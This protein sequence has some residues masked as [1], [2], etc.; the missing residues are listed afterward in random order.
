MN[1]AKE[2]MLRVYWD[3]RGIDSLEFLKRSVP[4]N[5]HLYVGRWNVSVNDWSKSAL[6]SPIGQWQG[7]TE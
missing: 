4:L 6:R 7:R 3:L 1:T 2:I 5:A